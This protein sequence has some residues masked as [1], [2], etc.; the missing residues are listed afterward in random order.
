MRNRLT[1][2]PSHRPATFAGYLALVMAAGPLVHFSMSA[3]GPLIVDSLEIS[4]TQFGLLWFAAFGTASLLSVAGGRMVDRYGA[5]TMLV[6]LFAVTLLALTLASSAASYLWILVALA[7]SGVAQSIANPLTNRLVVSEVP[8]A[9]HGVVL[10]IKQSGVQVGQLFAGLVL[11]SVAIAFGWRAAV[12]VCCV[13]VVVGLL[14]TPIIVPAAVTASSRSRAVHT[15]RPDTHLLLLALF[16]LLMG[17]VVQATNVYLPLY[18]HRELSASVATS[19]LVAAGLGGFGILGRLFWGRLASRAQDLGLVL[20]SM[21]VIALG[22]MAVIVLASELGLWLLWCGVLMFSFSALAINVVIMLSIVRAV[23]LDVV[24][25]ASGWVSLGIN[26]GFM[27]GPVM[28][29]LL[30]DSTLGFS[31]AWLTLAGIVFFAIVLSVGWRRWR[32]VSA[33][34]RPA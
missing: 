15:R 25:D 34:A 11:P 33:T 13:P 28:T 22:A 10:G 19:G 12:A 23:R 32:N 20:V 6:A 21:A 16:G 4:A 9:L 17:A 3:L 30:I 27:L 29:G 2:Q 26:L 1:G 7:L 18:A 24:G 31:G 14:L 5:R 8:A